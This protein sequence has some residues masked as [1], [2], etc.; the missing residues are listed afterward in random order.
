[1]TAEPTEPDVMSANDPVRVIAALKQV[2]ADQ[3]AEIDRIAVTDEL[4][5]GL[6]RRGFLDATE[7][8]R[9]RIRADG[10]TGHL[11]FID[12]DGLK[13]VNDTHGHAAGDDLIRRAASSIAATIGSG[14]VFGR[15]GGDELLVL[16]TTSDIEQL[17]Q[18]ILAAAAGVNAS[19]AIGYASFTRAERRGIN[20][21]IAA[22]GSAMYVRRRQR[23][24]VA[25]SAGLP[26]QRKTLQH[27]RPDQ[28][29]R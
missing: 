29:S 26:A 5:G 14:D 9:E 7:A 22:A 20:E 12:V 28:L 3:A 13:A 21:L 2:I 27:D 4:T 23:R 18:R 10:G 16:T 6:N 11:L 25:T 8:V 17:G 24:L 15:W 19:L 1:M